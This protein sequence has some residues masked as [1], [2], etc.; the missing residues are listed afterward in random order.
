MK[1]NNLKLLIFFLALFTCLFLLYQ[2]TGEVSVKHSDAIYGGKLEEGYES[3]SYIFSYNFDSDLVSTCG[4]VLLNDSTAITAAHC[5]DENASIYLGTKDFSVNPN[6]NYIV[7]NAQTNAKWKGSGTVEFDLAVIK[8]R[9][10]ISG[11]SEFAVISAPKEGCNY[12]IVGYGQTEIEDDL[13]PNQKLRKSTE[14]CIE[15][16]TDELLFIKSK[17]GGVCFGDS[18]SPI[19]EK[20]TNKIVGL[21]SAIYSNDKDDADCRLNNKA[22]AVNIKSQIGFV[23]KFTQNQVVSASKSTCDQKC[24]S[25][26]ECE[27]LLICKNNKCLPSMGSDCVSDNAAYCSL[28]ENVSCND[29][30]A[31]INQSCRKINKID[32]DFKIILASHRSFFN[33]KSTQ[34]KNILIVMYALFL[35]LILIIVN[36]VLIFVRNIRFKKAL[37]IIEL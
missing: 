18:G 22:I 21:L 23:N 7:S 25:D 1:K 33:E 6:Q 20:G 19:F 13:D 30:Y 4:T 35:V 17:D 3:A 24:N 10:K 11:I 8:P 14:I 31:C 16:F 37:K 5:I 2:E 29:N 26:S 27:G 32:T 28:F 15:S 34:N 12:E 9:D 36:I